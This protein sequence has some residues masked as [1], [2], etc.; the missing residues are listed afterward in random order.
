MESI[1]SAQIQIT[2]LLQSIQQFIATEADQAIIHPPIIDWHHP[3]SYRQN[4]IVGLKKFLQSVENERDY[5]TSLAESEVPPLEVASNIPYYQAVWEQVRY[6][7]WPIISIGQLFRCDEGNRKLQIKVDLVEDGGR[8]WVKVNTIKESRL[9]AEFREQDSYLNSD[10]ADEDDSDSSTSAGPSKQPLANSLI[11]QAKLLLKASQIHP[12]IDGCPPPKVKYVLNRLEE[13]PLG[14]YEDPRIPETF[15]TIRQMGI[16]LILSSSRRTIPKRPIRKAV[17]PTHK[18]LLDL[19]VLVALCC[20]STHLPLPNSPEE[21]E[22]RFRRLRLT[23]DG[24]VVLADH[25]PVTKD[26]RDQLEWEMIHPL[27]QELLD[28]L[29]PICDNQGE[30]G[31]VEFWVT[32]EVRGRLPGIV[33]II[34]GQNEKRRAKIMFSPEVTPEG[35]G[36]FWEGSRWKE[37]IESEQGAILRDMRIN[38]LP[39]QY[40]GE[41]CNADEM[42]TSFRK[43]FV[44]TVQKMLDIVEIQ[45]YNK[46]NPSPVNQVKPKAKSQDKKRRSKNPNNPPKEGITVESKLPSIHTLRTFLV[47]FEKNWTVLTNNRGS[48]GKVLREMRIDEGLGYVVD[49]KDQSEVNGSME[50]QTGGGVER[51]EGDGKVDIWVVNPSSLSEWRRKEVEQKNAKLR[52][53]LGDPGNEKSYRDWLVENDQLDVEEGNR[54][55]K[56]NRTGT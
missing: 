26:L 19:S 52:E 47:G 54:W 43:G 56:A 45:E 40:T 35:E 11:T 24:E 17:H 10:Y 9:M 33:D 28:R 22:S 5:I 49:R 31:K 51:E 46:S 1:S 55:K 32:H 20:D 27:I 48:V 15:Q 53:Y 34:G 29:T 41:G 13:T 50:G 39:P 25:I 14:G 16:D 23:A 42:D 21:L 38:V 30:G 44:S 2:D 6:A 4:T 12:R 18:I 36:D 3:N 8:G 7:Q 37:V